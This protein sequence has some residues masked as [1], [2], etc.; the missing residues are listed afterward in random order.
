MSHS[1]QTNNYKLPLFTKQDRPAWLTDFNGAMKAID[2]ELAE[3]NEMGSGSALPKTGGTMS[4][5]IDMGDHSI[6]NAA[7]IEL[8]NS[9]AGLF[10]GSVIQ[11]DGTS[12]ARLTG[13]TDGGA[14]IV[15]ADK[16]AVYATLAVGA[17]TSGEHAVNKN[18]LNGTLASY[19]K[20]SGATMTGALLLS[21][22]PTEN[23]QAATKQYVDNTSGGGFSEKMADAKYVQLAGST[24][25]GN[26]I[27]NGAPT[28]D[29]QAATKAYVD[30]EIQAAIGDAIAASY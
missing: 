28:G 2:A 11:P 20:K 27:L 21:G 8:P 15:E 16:Q 26:L 23:L 5:N 18:S 9:G 13:T 25:T 4:G 30:S 22:D 29:M 14:A 3:L 10:V 6:I 19:V 12:G 17:P 24:M 7:E 1:A